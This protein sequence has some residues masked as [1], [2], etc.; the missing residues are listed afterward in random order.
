MEPHEMTII[1]MIFSVEECISLIGN[2]RKNT[3]SDLQL[4][5]TE[6]VFSSTFPLGLDV[7]WS[8]VRSLVE[9]HSRWKIA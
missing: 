9:K 3:N 8:E 6:S 7:S 4:I 5:V 2:T 1:A